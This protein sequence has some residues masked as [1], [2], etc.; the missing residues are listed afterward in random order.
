MKRLLKASSNVDM[1]ELTKIQISQVA[2]IREG[3]GD[4]LIRRTHSSLR[5]DGTPLS[6]LPPFEVKAFYIE[7]SGEEKQVLQT[8]TK[9]G[10]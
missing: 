6:N 5:Y 8:L 10:V 9:E 2:Q 1:S 7:L 4:R 3:Y